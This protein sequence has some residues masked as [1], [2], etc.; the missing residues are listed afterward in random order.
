M[1]TPIGRF[2]HPRKLAM[3]LGIT[4]MAIGLPSCS[5]FEGSGDASKTP[6]VGKRTPV[7]AR[8]E[9]GAEVDPNIAG[10]SVILPPAIL[11]TDWTQP[12]GNAAKAMGHLQMTGNFSRAWTTGI[13]GSTTRYRLAATP[14]VLNG[15]LY[16]M[17]TD[18]VVYSYNAKTGS[19][20]WSTG[21]LR[22]Q[23]D[24]KQSAFGGGVSAENGKVFATNGV[25][26]VAALNANDG[27]VIWR[28]KPALP[29]ARCAN[30][31]L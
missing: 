20:N 7:L 16:V 31:G 5:I 18:G 17:D 21:A 26:E 30:I 1:M 14:V 9:S 4:A 10:V 13:T 22:V 8:A 19:K 3:V 12:G 29:V 25:G 6:T 2:F 11:N 15:N 24:G 27:S 23:G 28:K